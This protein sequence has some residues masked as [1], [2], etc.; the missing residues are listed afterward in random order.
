MIQDAGYYYPDFNIEV[1]SNLLNWVL[2]HHDENLEEY[3]RKNQEIIKRYTVEND[4]LVETYDKL[5][6]NLYKKNR[7]LDWKYDWKTNISQ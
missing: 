4:K 1:G 2:R 6:K 7:K 3:N 5:I